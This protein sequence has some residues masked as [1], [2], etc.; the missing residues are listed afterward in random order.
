M[1]I[2]IDLYCKPRTFERFQE[3]IKVLQGGSKGDLLLPISGFNPMAKDHI[4]E[5]LSELR[6]LQAEQIIKD[7]LLQL[8]QKLYEEKPQAVFKVAFNLADDLKG[9]WTNR[10]TSDYESKFKIN[11][12]VKRNFCIPFF[13]TSETFDAKTIVERTRQYCYRT[14]Y[15][16]SHPKPRTLKEHILQEVEVVRG[17]DVKRKSDFDI[18]ALS[19]FYEE[20]KDSTDYLV[21]LNFLYGDSATALLG[22]T[23]LGIE[24]E[25]A[26][27]RYA[28]WL[29]SH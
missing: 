7:T 1:D 6:A 22:N 17:S 14:I 28:K 20:N 4:L 21:I 8:N 13:W 18:E 12:F 2:L 16:Q 11:A 5:K 19:T 26:G 24:E 25:L 23:P 9:S 15:W 10:F 27:F 3:Y 29:A